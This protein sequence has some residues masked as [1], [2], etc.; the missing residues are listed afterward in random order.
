MLWLAMLWLAMLWLAAVPPA[1][2]ADPTIT[3][4]VF[5]ISDRKPILSLQDVLAGEDQV[6]GRQTLVICPVKVP[7]KV[8]AAERDALGI[9]DDVGGEAGSGRFG[10]L[11]SRLV[12]KLGTELPAQDDLLKL[13]I[14]QVNF[15]HLL[16]SI[17]KFFPQARLTLVGHSMGNRVI[18]EYLLQ[19]R[20]PADREAIDAVRLVRSDSGLQAFLAQRESIIGGINRFY[21]Y[22]AGSDNWLK[23]SNGLSSTSPRLGA[24]EKL[25]PLLSQDL[26]SA[27]NLHVVDI[28]SLKLWHG[29][30]FKLIAEFE[31]SP[32]IAPAD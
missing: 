31:K 1:I 25:S 29:I 20:L 16:E 19:H 30:P 26:D 23:L 7:F 14:S 18:L 13:E 5:V 9:L 6:L 10:K 11:K 17:H 28:S 4:P 27:P 24:P 21:I 22:Y 32:A 8:K 15:N 3:V 2:C 12:N